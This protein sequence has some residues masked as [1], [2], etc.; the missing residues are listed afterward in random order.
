[1]ARPCTYT[2]TDQNGT[3]QTLGMSAFQAYLAQGGLEH[4]F[5]DR[6][7]PWT[8]QFSR[9]TEA[10]TL[11]VSPPQRSALWQRWFG[12]SRMV[13]N[14]EPIRFYHGTNSDFTVFDKSKLGG[15]TQ[16]S[17]AKLGHFFTRNP[18]E[19]YRYGDKVHEVFLSV[20]NPYVITTDQL[21]QRMGDSPDRFADNLQQQGYDGIYLKDIGQAIVF[22]SNQ[23]KLT[24][25]VSPT[26]G[27]DIRYSRPALQKSLEELTKDDEIFKHPVSDA[28]TLEKVMEEVAPQFER[29]PQYESDPDAIGADEGATVR[30]YLSPAGR[31][32]IIKEKNGKVWLNVYNLKPGDKGGAIYAAVGNY[33]H[34]AGLEFIDDPEGVTAF[35][36]FRRPMHMLSLALRFGSTKFLG[37]SENFEKES[38]YYNLP[39]LKWAESTED[40]RIANLITRNTMPILTFLPDLEDYYYDFRTGK[41]KNDK[42]GG[43]LP[44]DW[45]IIRAEAEDARG[46]KIGETTIRRGVFLKSLASETSGEKSRLL[47]YYGH[48]G[49]LAGGV[50]LKGIFSRQA[51]EAGA[52]ETLSEPEARQHLVDN[53]GV[54]VDNLIRQKVLNFTD[55]KSTWPEIAQKAARGD[56]EAVYINGKIYIDLAAT[57]KSRLNA[58]LLHEIGEHFGLRRMLGDQAYR[59]LQQQIT[60][61]A[62]IAG[63]KAE[64]VWNE[65]KANYGH[66]Q[67]GSDQFVAEVIAKLGESDPKVPWFKRLLSQ[68]KAFMMRMGLAR[69]I[70]SGTISESDLHDLLRTSLQS[71]ARGFVKEEPRLYNVVMASVPAWHGTPHEVDKFDISKIGTGEGA[72]AFGHG[73]YFTDAKSIAEFYRDTLSKQAEIT[74]NGKKLINRF[75]NATKGRHWIIDD[76]LEHQIPDKFTNEGVLATGKKA[77]Q[78]KPELAQYLEDIAFSEPLGVFDLS[79]ETSNVDLEQQFIDWL[80]RFDVRI[81][82][83]KLYQVELAPEQDEYLDWDKP[84]S[85]QSE[86]VKGALSVIKNPDYLNPTKGKGADLYARLSR[87][88]GGDNAASDYLHS[89]GIRGIRYKAEG[90]KSDASNYVIFKDEDVSI[91]ARF[92]RPSISELKDRLLQDAEGEPTLAAQALRKLDEMGTAVFKQRF[93]ALS[94]MQMVE[95]AAHVMPGLKEYERLLLQQRGAQASSQKRIADRLVSEVWKKL[96]TK[97]LRA[98]ADAQHKSTLDDVDASLEWSGIMPNLDE[99]GV[100]DGYIAFTQ[101]ALTKGRKLKLAELAMKNGALSFDSKH[102]DSPEYFMSRR[103]FKFATADKAQQFVA[104]IDKAVAE[105]RKSRLGMLDGNIKRRRTH[106]ELRA[107]FEAL[108]QDA[109]FVYT[110][111]NR[112]HGDLSEKLLATQIDKL[113]SAIENVEKR[114]QLIAQMR[115]EFESRSLNWYYAPLSRFGNEWFYGIDK[116]GNRVFSTFKTARAR[117]KALQR[118]LNDNGKKIGA[119]KVLDNLNVLEGAPPSDSFILDMHK[120]VDEL[121]KPGAEGQP[122]Q[123]SSE[124]AQGLKDQIYQMYLATLPEV[125]VRHNAMHREGV[126]GFEEDS[127]QSFSNAMHHGANQLANMMYAGQMRDVLYMHEEAKNL[128]SRPDKKVKVEA[129]IEAAKMLSG[130]WENLTEKGKLEEL[131]R[132]VESDLEDAKAF[133][134]SAEIDWRRAIK[135]GDA[136]VIAKTRE[137]VDRAEAM[138]SKAEKPAFKYR[139]AI[140]L[141]NRIGTTEHSETALD[142]IIRK[143]EQLLKAAGLI[144]EKDIS[145]VADLLDELLLSY[146]NTMNYNSS[147]MDKAASAINQFN[148]MTMLGFSISSGMVNLLQNPGVAMPI[149]IG[150]YGYRATLKHF[151]DAYKEF[152]HSLVHRKYDEDGNVS[153]STVLEDRYKAATNLADQQRLGD[154]LKAMDEFKNGGDVSRTRSFDLQGIG[155]EGYRYGGM[156]HDFTQKAGWM[157][158]HGERLNREVALMASYR[159]A[160]AGENGVKPMEHYQAVEYAR[161]VNNRAHLDYSS[162]NAARIFRGP[163]AKVA[164]QFKKYQQGMMFL[165]TKTAIDAW[166]EVKREN[167]PDTAEGE[168][169]YKEAEIQK[170]ESIRTFKALLAMQVSL[171]G[172]FGLPMVGVLSAA[173]SMIA[174]AFGDDDEVRELQKDTRLGLAKAVRYATEPLLGKEGAESFAKGF[175]E[176]FVKG[177]VNALTEVNLA[178]R[179][180]QSDIFFREPMKELEGRDAMQHYVAQ[181]FGPFGGSLEKVAQGVHLAADGYWGRAAES[182]APKFL[183][184]PFKALRYLTEDAKTLDNM[185]LKDMAVT[186]AAWQAIGFGSS[187][188]ER[189]YAERG[190]AKGEEAAIKETRTK[191]MREAAWA[192]INGEKV[193]DSI[194]LAWNKKHPEKPILPAHIAASVK[195]LRQSVEKRKERGY[196]VDP[197]LEYLYEEN[198]LAD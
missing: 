1:M 49:R 197:K 133:V 109:K 134:S 110:E 128:A 64:K 56:E 3:E 187:E 28:T 59:S 83:G 39:P 94:V 85:E 40:E 161:Y 166:K 156:F 99:E 70:V 132:P 116:D 30:V 42:L 123:L 66:L 69:G 185:P 172:A 47:E 188:L 175:A 190:Y 77:K 138:V 167:F 61:R 158:H 4:L 186:E 68:I 170:K 179:L 122:P 90:G 32:I 148:F 19:A 182:I 162:E 160:R 6:T 10:P 106:S 107:P 129:E 96:D 112:L 67:E 62:K 146:N 143:N 78:L 142:N 23:A 104:E 44:D 86:K 38:G 103:G 164:L 50:S 124:A 136:E 71:A 87:L 165:W 95:Y 18:D 97:T 169:L 43:I 168:K 180:D 137:R 91:T 181:I 73:L 98:L 53:F 135:D 155:Q 102:D 114:K 191:I 21:D 12:K 36:L 147:D 198:E 105:Q 15:A 79:R 74:L 149:A 178:S 189:K 60:N 121:T 176:A 141:R 26:F 150:K 16:H 5:P 119:G 194:R 75:S 108:P 195:G 84:L 17:T 14:G 8:P 24:S 159:M 139:K 9:P 125:S 88:E 20:Q 100:A 81:S 41:F 48:D 89:L 177:G 153:I 57:D 54:G 25:N 31:P 115:S 192:R 29:R 13:S 183:G 101:E 184:D 118:F 163:L 157:F 35:A 151:G 51:P 92:S 58:V 173:Y 145:K 37:V 196:V 82:K 131:S 171:A 65:V 34:N 126:L 152:M 76:E 174:N 27:D 45:A 93:A 117:D 80:S 52:L 46:A 63:S 130:D 72:Q 22:N 7:F 127:M 111:S 120:L 55:G 154:E 144:L 140:E 193:D 113:S 33:A 2:F 11:D